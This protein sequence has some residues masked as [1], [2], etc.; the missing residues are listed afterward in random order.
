MEN[1]KKHYLWLAL[2]LILAAFLRFWGLRWGLPY[3]YQS[4]EYK[5]I[6]YALNMGQQKTLNPNFFEYPTLYLYFIL[7]LYGGYFVFG[8]IIGIFPTVKAFAY[9]FIKDP[10]GFYI[11][12]RASES[13]F[14]IG[15]VL[16]TY[17]I[18]KKIFSR[19]AGLAAAF[20]IAVLPEFINK[21]HFTKGD[22]AAV[23]LGL[24]F[25][26]M[27][28]K[29]FE[30]GE[31]KYY[32]WS[33]IL[34]GLAISTKYF[35]AV[36]GMALL[37][38]HFTSPH[39]SSH[40]PLL[41][42]L[43]LIPIFFLIGSPYFAVSPAAR[44]FFGDFKSIFLSFGKADTSVEHVNLFTRFLEAGRRLIRL[45]DFESQFLIGGY[46]FGILS[47]IGM[48][49]LAWKRKPAALILVA[50]VVAYW[51]VVGTYHNPAAGYL[52]PCLPLFLICGAWLVFEL[53]ETL[54]KGVQIALIGFFVFSVVCALSH[55]AKIA[56]Y[57]TL[58][59]TRTEAKEWIDA[60]LPSKSK[61]LMDLPVNSP[62][63]EMTVGQLQKFY[64]IAV[65]ENHLKKDYFRLKLE[66]QD[67]QA[68]AYEIWVLKRTPTEIGSLPSQ[69]E[70]AQKV[71]D[72]V[73]VE[74]GE[75]SVE[76]IKKAG[77]QYVIVSSYSEDNAKNLFPRLAKFYDEISAK[78]KLI[79]TFDP[80][81]KLHPGPS[82]RIYQI[83]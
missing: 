36:I 81:T 37:V 52:E 26:L 24:L 66:V 3:Q 57:Y 21:A 13:I 6:K 20:M 60:N 25:V 29:I 49:I 35:L 32:V 10:S 30:T 12:G 27:T 7:V 53:S 70:Q 63:L 31:L 17:L 15:V 48:G 42:A 80:A 5:V 38:S 43:I 47:F 55:S 33:G 4:E 28:L 44:E 46:G 22:M 76:K 83:K 23:F 19:K 1:D 79:K 41:I 72:L 82:I 34:L 75:K 78:T 16:L 2:I 61:V 71:Q 74:D 51:I 11:I 18:G 9:Q 64:D 68:P 67:P 39:R 14:G 62:P 73:H 59:D 54:N 65:K 69:V 8:K 58:K 40:R 50:T 45:S 56:Y 77:I